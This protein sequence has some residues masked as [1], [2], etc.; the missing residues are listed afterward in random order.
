MCSVSNVPVRILKTV[1]ET[2]RRG[3]GIPG[4][5]RR[6]ISL[7]AFIQKYYTIDLRFCIDVFQKN[8]SLFFKNF[9]NFL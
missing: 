1:R 4:P 8:F 3:S 7:Y 9:V 5:S 6:K 2:P